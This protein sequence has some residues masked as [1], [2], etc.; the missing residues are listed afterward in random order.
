[1]RNGGAY[2]HSPPAQ[3]VIVPDPP[4]SLYSPPPPP[5]ITCLLGVALGSLTPAI[6]SAS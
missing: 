1:M 5:P 6:I 4:V 2:K 3:H